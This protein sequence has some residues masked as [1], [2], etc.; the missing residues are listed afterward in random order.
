MITKSSE[1]HNT[2]KLIYAIIKCA[3]DDY[4]T[5]LRGR[6]RFQGKGLYVNSSTE[7]F[8]NSEYSDY[9]ISH[10]E[11]NGVRGE[12]IVEALKEKEAKRKAKRKF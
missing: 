11:L 7:S 8:F 3:V 4:N 10:T 2:D 6:V 9:L 5:E 1:I 12:D